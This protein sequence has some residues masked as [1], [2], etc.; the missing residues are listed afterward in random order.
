MKILVTLFTFSIIALISCSPKTIEAV[1]ETEETSTADEMPK[2]DIGEG[3]VV[4]LK[5]CSKCHQMKTVTDF[6]KDQW[7]GILP[8]MIKRAKLSEDEARQVSSYI[9]WALENE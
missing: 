4:Y 5:D 6:T 7:N 2:T 3:K 9:Y 8:R 1:T